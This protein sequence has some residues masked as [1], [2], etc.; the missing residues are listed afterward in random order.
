MNPAPKEGSVASRPVVAWR[1]AAGVREVRARS[2]ADKRD[3][4]TIRAAAL[5]VLT[6]EG[7]AALAFARSVPGLDPPEFV[8]QVVQGDELV[9]LWIELPPRPMGAAT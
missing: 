9:L 1:T 2:P 7:Y 4:K 3:N 8:R 5:E 6:Q